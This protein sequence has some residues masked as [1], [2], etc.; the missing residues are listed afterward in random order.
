MPPR[1]SHLVRPGAGPFRPGVLAGRHGHPGER[2]DR[3]GLG[4]HF[5]TEPIYTYSIYQ[6]VQDGVLAPIRPVRVRTDVDLDQVDS[7]DLDLNRKQ[8]GSESG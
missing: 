6:A 3:R 7:D 2:L 5:G 1:R 8:L 4:G